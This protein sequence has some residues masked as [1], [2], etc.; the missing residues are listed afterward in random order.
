MG[1]PKKKS[2]KLEVDGAGFRFM[3]KDGPAT[4]DPLDREIVLTVQEDSE[5]PGRVLHVALPYGYAVG[6]EA[7]RKLVR[8]GL[9]AGWAPTERGG[10]F[11]LESF[12]L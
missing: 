2:R 7:I 12:V 6:P 4:Q 9:S 3:I 5:T 10:P 8:Q 1:I 11:N